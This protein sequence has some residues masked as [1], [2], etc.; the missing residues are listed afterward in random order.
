M[1]DD[2]LNSNMAF[3][4]RELIRDWNLPTPNF[5]LSAGKTQLL[6]VDM[7]NIGCTTGSGLSKLL[8]DR[9]PEKAEYLQS[10]LSNKVIP[11]IIKLLGFFRENNLGIIYL[12][13]GAETQD[14]SDY[15]PLYRQL[16]NA[17]ESCGHSVIYK[18]TAQHAI[19]PSLEPQQGEMVLNKTTYGAFNSTG[20]DII[21]RNSDTEGLIITGVSTDCCVESTARDAADRGFKCVIAED[22]CATHSAFGHEASLFA[23]ARYFGMVKTAQEIITNLKRA[24]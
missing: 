16:I 11:N 20:L 14:A 6:I 21:L 23:F 2:S 15:N 24:P 7:Q 13:L 4:W 3:D 8:H 10:R 12:T 18:G 19:I 9:S 22:A 1:E 17:V 5:E